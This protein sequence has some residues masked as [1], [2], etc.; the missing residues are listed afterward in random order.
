VLEDQVTAFPHQL[1]ADR[2]NTAKH[3]RKSIAVVVQQLNL[4]IRDVDRHSGIIRILIDNHDIRPGR[5]NLRE[6]FLT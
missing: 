2:H 1:K 5:Q 6:H 4:R 3:M